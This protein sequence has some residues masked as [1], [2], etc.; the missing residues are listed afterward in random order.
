MPTVIVGNDV[1][2][3]GIVWLWKAF[4]DLLT[5]SKALFDLGHFGT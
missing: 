3:I 5:V 4:L 1:N 2:D